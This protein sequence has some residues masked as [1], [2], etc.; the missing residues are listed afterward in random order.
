[1]TNSSANDIPSMPSGVK[2][3]TLDN[4]IVWSAKFT[5]AVKPIA[6]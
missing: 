6:S 4:G 5:R 2:I 3:T 1:M